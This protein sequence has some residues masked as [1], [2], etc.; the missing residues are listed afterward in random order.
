MSS[1]SEN[2]IK[3]V[4][5]GFLKSFYRLRPRADRAPTLTGTDMRG[6]G[7]II[8]DG[9][10]SFV[11]PDN[12]AFT[13]T[14]EATS[15]NTR[16]EVRY[17]PRLTHILWDSIA[18]SLLITATLLAFLHI[19]KVYLMVI[20]GFT[21]F[22]LGLAAFLMVTVI[23]LRYTLFPLPRYRTIFAIEQ[24]KQ[25]QADDQW[26]AI[27]YDVF[28]PQESKYRRELIRQCTKFGFGL[29]EIDE[30]RRPQL[31]LAPSRAEN[32]VPKQSFTNLIPMGAWGDR[33]GAATKGPIQ[34]IRDWFNQRMMP[35]QAH[36][37]RWFPRTYYHQWILIILSLIA[38]FFFLRQEYQRLPI[39]YANP[40]VYQNQLSKKAENSRPESEYF[41][42]D[43]PEPGFFDSTF[44]P[45]VVPTNEEQFQNII[46]NTPIRDA[47]SIYLPPLR[48]ISAQPGLEAA[49]YYSC[50][51]FSLQA[52]PYFVVFDT[53]VQDLA[54]ARYQLAELNDRG[55]SGTAVWRSCLDT[56]GNGFYIF[57]D[58][59][60]QDS[61]N[62]VEVR[63]S[64]QQQLDSLHAPLQ[65][66]HFSPS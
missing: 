36:Y 61:L 16:Q 64:L 52:R 12:T 57:V 26:V 7:G 66:R 9:F 60:F 1:L 5:L 4:A 29:I 3:Q 33:L 15:W 23:L 22:M 30:Q 8:A 59:I 11:Q 55:L 2:T 47:D 35:Y 34:R 10:L 42:V 46:Q 51:R 38:L 44:S 48:I 40:Q 58:D 53:L 14:L 62:A 50:D 65:I 49:L 19:F 41:I 24:F 31:V 21:P 17:R 54:E 56:V 28:S 27:G 37:F 6:K 13:A 25:Y 18:L 63:D 43:A 45:F 32:F 20:Y 39:V